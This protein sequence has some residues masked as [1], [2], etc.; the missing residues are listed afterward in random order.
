MI[1]SEINSDMI[2]AD[3]CVRM[4]KVPADALLMFFLI[5]YFFRGCVP[6]VCGLKASSVCGLKLLVYAA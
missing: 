6:H 5:Y 2:H 4:R 1:C 3:I